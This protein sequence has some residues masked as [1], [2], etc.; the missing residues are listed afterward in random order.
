MPKIKQAFWQQDQ[1]K[2]QPMKGWDEKTCRG[3]WRSAP[4]QRIPADG[5]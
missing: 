1:A 4:G 5:A 3:S 2:K